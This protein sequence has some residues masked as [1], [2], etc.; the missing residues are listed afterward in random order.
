MMLT[1]NGKFGTWPRK[2]ACLLVVLVTAACSGDAR[3]SGTPVPGHGNPIAMQL[4][5]GTNSAL[6]SGPGTNLVD[7][8]DHWQTWL[9]YASPVSYDQNTDTLQIPAPAGNDELTHAIRRYDIQLVQ[10]TRYHLTVSATDS[11]AGAV[12]FLI[13]QSGEVLPAVS[14]NNG[15]LVVATP[16]SPV[17]F[18]A[19]AG[20]AGFY[21]QVQNAWRSATGTSLRA[22]VSPDEGTG[23]AGDNL[24]TLDAP[25]TDWTGQPTPVHVDAA[26]A[27]LVV[28]PPASRI[29]N[30]YGLRRFEQPLVAHEEYELSALQASDDQVAVLLF[31]LDSSGHPIPFING[32]NQSPWLKATMRQTARFVAPAGVA[33][34]GIQVQS[35]WNMDR[36]SRISPALRLAQSEDC[37]IP[38][39]FNPIE[40]TRIDTNTG[41]I[42]DGRVATT[43]IS[44]DGRIV[45]FSSLATNF[46]PGLIDTNGTPPLIAAKG[47]DYFYH[48]RDTGLSTRISDGISN[49]IFH[50]GP[51]LSRNGRFITYA[52]PANVYYVDIDS[53]D[54]LK[55]ALT[56]DRV[57][58]TESRI[59]DNGRIAF[60][61][62]GSDLVTGEVDGNGSAADVFLLD[63]ADGQIKRVSA[64]TAGSS[65]ES[66]DI[67]ADGRFVAYWSS[68]IHEPGQPGRVDN[69]KAL[70]LYDS[71]T[72]RTSVIGYD[73]RNFASAV[74]RISSGGRFTVFGSQLGSLLP[75]AR[76][77][78][79]S[80]SD[81]FLYDRAAQSLSRITPASG[82]GSRPL[83]RFDVAISP[84]G[85]HV[86]FN[87]LSGP[88]VYQRASGRVE[89]LRLTLSDSEVA[90]AGMAISSGGRF[91]SFTSMATDLV[92]QADLNPE[93]DLFVAQTRSAVAPGSCR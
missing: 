69:V 37:S 25:W 39:S 9:G 90:I 2:L 42:P 58:T 74:P 1:S 32:A 70:R 87:T 66:P 4:T 82:A 24:V 45:A 3:H 7:L 20:V 83:G 91:I 51:W 18:A 27:Q 76:E 13:L 89:P 15:A 73:W 43:G 60:T 56:D 85:S 61:S 64:G 11:R 30:T 23:S 62:G 86:V 35:G 52:G 36:E 40:V 75:G 53:G 34:F 54:G 41:E 17:S 21:L 29:G 71:A 48:D 49:E 10:G 65:A 46:V 22:E 80:T 26:T 77:P 50:S 92:P 81:L 5:L 93:S 33:G 88:F 12:L 67:S 57:A 72:G 55:R 59:S 6:K 28:P 79:D 31:L 38:G 84:E 19:P 68:G 8:S 78:N 44:A 47:I 16:G 14:D 63:Q